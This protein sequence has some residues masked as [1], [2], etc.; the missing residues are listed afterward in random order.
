[1]AFGAVAVS[2]TVIGDT[3]VLTVITLLDVTTKGGGSTEFDRGHG[4]TLRS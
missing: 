1:L 3:L 4:A 2:T